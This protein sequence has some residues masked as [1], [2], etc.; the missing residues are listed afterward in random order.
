MALTDP[1]FLLAGLTL[2]AT[3]LLGF[4][5][6]RGLLSLPRLTNAGRPDRTPAVTV[7]MAAR[8]EVGS[9]ADAVQSIVRQDYPSLE[10]VAVDD[11]S[12]DGTGEI[13]D[14]LAEKHAHLRVLH[15]DALPD[16]WLGKNHALQ[17]GAEVATGELLLFTDAD[18]MLQPEAVTRAVALLERDGLDHLA[19]APRIHVGSA[20]ASMTVAVFLALFSA[21]FRPWK[22]RNPRSRHYIGIGAFNLVRAAAYQSIGGHGAVPLRPDDDVRLGRAIKAAGFRQ[23]AAVGTRMADVEWYP[24]LPAMARGLRKNAFAVVEYRLGLVAAGTLVPVLFIFWPLA[25]LGVT[26]GW[27]WWLNAAVLAGGAAT[28]LATARAHSLPAWTAVTFPL[29]S[30][31]LLWIVWAAALRVLRTGTVEWRGT[32]YSLDRLRG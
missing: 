17:Q 11:R 19:V 23:A 4:D 28:I 3:L 12:S 16:G 13:L 5:L 26:G 18:V 8:D 31:L 20:A 32:E 10:L 6:A 9:I 14:H 24:T 21:V 15:V 30:L 22:A 29:G 2:A 27:T 25:A 7:I 1:L